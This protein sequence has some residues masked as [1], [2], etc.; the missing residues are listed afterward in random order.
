MVDGDSMK[1]ILLYICFAL[2]IRTSSFAAVGCDLND[3]D[4]DVQRFF[5]ASTGYRTDYYTL[6]KLGDPDILS[7]IQ[8]R[9]GDKFKGLYETVDVPY[10][11]YT[12]LKNKDVIGYIHGV[13]QKGEYGGIQ[14]FMALDPQGVI[15]DLY[16]QKMTASYAE[17]FRDKKFTS[18]FKGMS[19]KDFA[20][21]DPVSGKFPPGIALKKISN[22]A[23][24]AKRDYLAILR[25]VKKNFILMDEFVFKGKARK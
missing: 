19:I 8:N 2:L 7:K 15:S 13:N 10:T 17:K 18:Q 20:D 9:L 25:G 24:E 14:V 1:K 6:K 12:V 22:P 16:F 23:P 11:V 5:P 3:P 4:R 21:Y